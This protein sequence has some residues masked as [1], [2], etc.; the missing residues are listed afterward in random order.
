MIYAALLA[1]G[2]GKRM[3]VAGLPK[4]FLPLN[5]KCILLH[6]LTQFVINPY[7][8][9][10]FVIVPVEWQIYTKNLLIKDNDFFLHIKKIIIT[11]GG[12][13]RNSSLMAAVKK[14]DE[15]YTIKPNDIIVTHDAVRPFVTQRIINDNINECY[16]HYAID[17]V[18][19]MNDTPII[20]TDGKTIQDIPLRS[21]IYISQTPQTFN[22]QMLKQIYFSLTDEEKVILTD[23]CK[24]FIIKGKKVSM[25]MGEQYNFKITTLFDYSMALAF[26]N[27][28]IYRND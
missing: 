8:D 22:I 27:N 26:I 13:D 21:N 23:A 17:T 18:Y 11:Q 3:H 28:D 4:Q 19:I 2:T 16:K 25:V 9:M 5:K 20:T 12:N 24:M 1:G 14:I 15:L 6:T 10:V 7:I